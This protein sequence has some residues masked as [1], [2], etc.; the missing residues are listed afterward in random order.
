MN[1]ERMI[2]AKNS[3]GKVTWFYETCAESWSP[4][5]DS[6]GALY[7]ANGNWVEMPSLLKLLDSLELP[8]GAIVDAEAALAW[9]IRND[10]PFPEP[11]QE[12]ASS[13]QL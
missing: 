12:F 10:T 4:S 11:I 9:F 13:R 7:F 5:W 3:K 2:G 8:I 1:N 6:D